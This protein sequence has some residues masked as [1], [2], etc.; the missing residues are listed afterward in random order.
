MAANQFNNVKNAII[1]DFNNADYVLTGQYPNSNTNLGYN[2][3][4]AALRWMNLAN[5]QIQG[6]A[7]GFFSNTPGDL[8]HAVSA[9]PG[10]SQNPGFAPL[11]NGPCN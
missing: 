2:C 9:L 7:R 8:G 11:S 6:V 1:D 4:D 5:A 3:A 10:A